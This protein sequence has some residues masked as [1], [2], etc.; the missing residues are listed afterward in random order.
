MYL[1]E[2]ADAARMLSTAWSCLLKNGAFL[3]TIDIK[4][5]V[6]R[7]KKKS[8]DPSRVYGV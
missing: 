3:Y 8:A 7:L 1:P 6:I 5:K 2:P 4:I